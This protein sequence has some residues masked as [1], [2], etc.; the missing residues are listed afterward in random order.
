[1]SKRKLP[2]ARALIGGHGNQRDSLEQM[3]NSLGLSDSVSFLGWLESRELVEAYKQ[4]TVFGPSL[5]NR[6]RVR[7]GA[8]GGGFDGKAGDL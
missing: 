4:S 6:G 1:M 8:R 7:N 3:A 5:C 2:T